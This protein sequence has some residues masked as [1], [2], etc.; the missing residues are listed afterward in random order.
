M[1]LASVCRQ[2]T[3]GVRTQAKAQNPH[4]HRHREAGTKPL[5]TPTTKPLSW[6]WLRCCRRS[7][8][9]AAS[10]WPV[11]QPVRT[12]ASAGVRGAGPF[13]NEVPHALGEWLESIYVLLRTTSYHFDFIL[14]LLTFARVRSQTHAA[15]NAHPPAPSIF[16]LKF[17]YFLSKLRVFHVFTSQPHP[18]RQPRCTSMSPTTCWLERGRGGARSRWRQPRHPALCLLHPRAM[19]ATRSRAGRVEGRRASQFS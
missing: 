1:C 18:H 16:I 2:R 10:R 15:A 7:S 6:A 12:G 4:R 8:S 3:A 17:Y 5:T 11:A 13:V 14:L 19:T 9:D